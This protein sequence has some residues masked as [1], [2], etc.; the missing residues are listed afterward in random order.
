MEEEGLA[1]PD[2]YP[3]SF[4]DMPKGLAAEG[5]MEADSNDIDDEKI[6]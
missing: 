1:L 6:K 5:L 4:D 3:R 2:D